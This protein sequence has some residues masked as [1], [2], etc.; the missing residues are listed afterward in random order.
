MVRVGTWFRHC[1]DVLRRTPF[2][3]IRLIGQDRC[4]H[5]LSTSWWALLSCLAALTQ[6]QQNSQHSSLP[7]KQLPLLLQHL[8]E[9]IKDKHGSQPGAHLSFLA[10]PTS[11]HSARPRAS[12]LCSFRSPLSLGKIGPLF[13]SQR[14]CRY[15]MC[16]TGNPLEGT[17]GEVPTLAS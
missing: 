12:T 4:C 13:L 14:H 7:G 2:S 15:V 10:P 8:E 16:S 1:S 17:R 11:R 6:P 9:T 5:S 3:P